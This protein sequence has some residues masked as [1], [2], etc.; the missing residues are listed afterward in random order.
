MIKMTFS[1]RIR[2]SDIFDEYARLH[3]IADNS[4]SVITFLA[5][6]NLLDEN[7]VKKFLAKNKEGIFNG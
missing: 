7:E 6:N 5:K 1:K 2:L 3:E 4:F